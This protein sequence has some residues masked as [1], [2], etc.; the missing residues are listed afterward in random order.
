MLTDKNLA[1]GWVSLTWSKE[2]LQWSNH[3]LVERRCQL[4]AVLE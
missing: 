1:D 2:E 3:Q 4:K